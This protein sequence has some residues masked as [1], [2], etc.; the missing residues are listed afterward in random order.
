MTS[1]E[2][3]RQPAHHENGTC[4]TSKRAFTE[5]PS[6]SIGFDLESKGDLRLAGNP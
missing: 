5:L 3:A 1:G 6:Q 2:V 4:L